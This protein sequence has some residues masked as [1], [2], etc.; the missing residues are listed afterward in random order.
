M[1]CNGDVFVSNFK[2]Y[3]NGENVCYIVKK[4]SAGAAVQRCS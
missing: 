3:N 4:S 1:A 2:A